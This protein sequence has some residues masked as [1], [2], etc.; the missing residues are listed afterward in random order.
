M[1]SS[2]SDS[3]IVEEYFT[4]ADRIVDTHGGMEGYELTVGD[5][6]DNYPKLFKNVKHPISIT[7]EFGTYNNILVGFALIYENQGWNYGSTISNVNKYLYQ[8]F[9]PNSI[10]YF[11]NVRERGRCVF[12]QALVI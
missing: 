3:G 2:N 7:Q 11:N 9:T 6:A 5:V 4:G 8:I 12:Y 1:V 10:E